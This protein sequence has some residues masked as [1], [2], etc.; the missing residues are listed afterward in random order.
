M[1]LFNITPDSYTPM[2]YTQTIHFIIS[3]A[4]LM[5]IFENI[6]II[7]F[8]AISNKI[9]KKLSINIIPVSKI[10]DIMHSCFVTIAFILFSIYLIK[11]FSNVIYLILYSYILFYAVLKA[12]IA[13]ITKYTTGVALKI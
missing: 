6:V 12:N 4:I 11:P 9:N 5:F 13:I 1:G 10:Q 7:V 3:L 2:T 8:Q